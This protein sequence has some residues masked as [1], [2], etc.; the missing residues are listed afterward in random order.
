MP[1]FL[2]HGKHKLSWGHNNLFSQT[3]KW[4]SPLSYILVLKGQVGKSKYIIDY[5]GVNTSHTV[6]NRSVRQMFRLHSKTKQTF[7]DLFNL[8]LGGYQMLIRLSH[9][10]Q[11]RNKTDN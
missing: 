8:E 10:L 3:E 9:K 1:Q 7:Q 4:D 2:N 5:Q 6:S 11:E